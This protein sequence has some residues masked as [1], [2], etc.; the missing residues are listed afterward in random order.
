MRYI[1][2]QL[3]A[4]AAAAAQQNLLRVEL[5]SPDTA[6]TAQELLAQLAACCP[7][8]APLLGSCRLAVNGRYV[9]N[10]AMLDPAAEIALIPPVSGG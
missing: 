5:P 6:L 9:G 2:V 8:L 4:G 10:D 1:E 7:P 3:F